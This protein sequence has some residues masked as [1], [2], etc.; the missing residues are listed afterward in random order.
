MATLRGFCGGRRD[1]VGPCSVAVSGVV[2]GVFAGGA[3]WVDFPGPGR[4]LLPVFPSFGPV[5]VV[6]GACL[7]GGACCPRTPGCTLCSGVRVCW[8]EHSDSSFVYGFMIL[9]YG[10]GTMTATTLNIQII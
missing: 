1:L 4:A 7:P 2:S 9:D 6:G 5:G 10:F 8:S 3:P